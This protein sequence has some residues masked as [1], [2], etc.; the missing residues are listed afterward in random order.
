MT[1]VSQQ[2]LDVAV[3]SCARLERGIFF[4]ALAEGQL[5]HLRWVDDLQHF[6]R[7]YIRALARRFERC[8]HPSLARAFAEHLAHELPH[9]A[10]LE[11]WRLQVG[12]A[13]GEPRLPTIATQDCARLMST[14][15]AAHDL[16]SAQAHLLHQVLVM[17]LAAES[18]GL[19]FYRAARRRL[20]I[21]GL[22][23]GPYWR[24]HELGDDGHRRVGLDYVDSL[25]L[26]T[27]VVEDAST[28][29]ATYVTDGFGPMLTS[30]V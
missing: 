30:W 5:D 16:S 17:N 2:L 29:V 8:E 25:E 12:R 1:K 20:E 23:V 6:G 4:H 24:A 26:S 3:T 13:V 11:D 7:Q 28:C 18:V 27:E 15:A 10:Q 22:D 19:S 9:V 21:L 14:C